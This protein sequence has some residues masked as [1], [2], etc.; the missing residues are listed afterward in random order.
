MFRNR[1]DF[2]KL[3]VIGEQVGGGQD[4]YDTSYFRPFFLVVSR[5]FLWGT[6]PGNFQN[7]ALVPPYVFF[8]NFGGKHNGEPL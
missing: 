8:E 2:S 6:L 3:D 4:F 5:N 1:V 7:F